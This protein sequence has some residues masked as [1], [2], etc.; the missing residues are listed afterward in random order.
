MRFVAAFAVMIS[1]LVSQ[2]TGRFAPDPPFRV[3]TTLGPVGVTFFFVLSGF[4]L[5]WVA[6]PNDTAWLFW[7]RR[8]VKLYPNHL[9]TFVAARIAMIAVGVPIVAINTFP[10]LFLVEP[11]IPLLDP[12]GGFRGSNSVSWSLGCEL[13]FYLCFPWLIHWIARIRPER[14][15][16][17]AGGVLAASTA[18][19]FVSHL[20]PTGPYTAWDPTSSEWQSWFT[21][22]LPPLRMLEF[23]LGILTARIVIT[24]KWIRVGLL[25]T[26]VLAIAAIFIQSYLP[27]VFHLRSGLTM[28]AIALLLSAAATADTRAQRTPFSGRIMVYLGEISFAIYMVHYL[29]IL[30]GPV[31]LIHA[32]GVVTDSVPTRLLNIFLTI[33]ITMVLSMGLYHLV[34]KPMVRRFSRPKTKPD[35]QPDRESAVS[36]LIT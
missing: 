11:W 10:A 12:H 30:Y 26:S 23:V 18:V 29:V 4:I 17:W 19:P 22:Q 32:T 6:D 13:L 1:H 15:W 21:Y 20:L 8:L 34:E 2:I 24:G 9:V 7:R 27:N 25:P 36:N 14:L 16:W 28:L 31:D 33:V 5:T 3:I 35:P